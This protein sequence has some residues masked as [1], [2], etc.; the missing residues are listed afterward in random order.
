MLLGTTDGGSTWSKV[1][2]SAPAGASNY[3]EQSY[4]SL[5]FI[6]CPTAN[7]CIANGTTA[8]GSP[9]APIYSLT[10]RGSGY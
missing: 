7:V 4:L 6:T 9:T 8:Q 2:F 10:Q 1:T 5:G 3:D